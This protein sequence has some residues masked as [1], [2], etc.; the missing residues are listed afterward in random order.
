VRAAPGAET[1]ILAEDFH[2]AEEGEEAEEAEEA[3]E[4]SNTYTECGQQSSWRKDADR[5]V[6]RF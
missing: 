3:K 2:E 4:K 5:R 1:N 6:R